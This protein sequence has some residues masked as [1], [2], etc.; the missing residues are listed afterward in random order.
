MLS[1]YI[2]ICYRPVT[3]NEPIFFVSTSLNSTEITKLILNNNTSNIYILFAIT[4]K[5]RK[6]R[7]NF[8]INRKGGRLKKI[9]ISGRYSAVGLLEDW[10]GQRTPGGLFFF[11]F[12]H[13]TFRTK[14]IGPIS[15]SFT[16]KFHRI[17]KRMYR[18]KSTWRQCNGTRAPIHFFLEWTDSVLVQHSAIGPTTGDRG[19]S[20]HV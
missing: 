11:M 15:L 5:I 10:A 6:K 17:A 14:T 8:K 12:S 3:Q 19:Y 2:A 20:A 4:S 16:L 13:H 9:P 18:P 7:K 1:E